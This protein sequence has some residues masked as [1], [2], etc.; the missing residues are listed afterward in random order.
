LYSISSIKKG[1]LGWSKLIPGAG[2]RLCLIPLRFAAQ[3]HA[4][5]R[6]PPPVVVDLLDNLI[7]QAAC[8]VQLV[9]VL[10]EQIVLFFKPLEFP[11]QGMD[12]GNQIT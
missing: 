12:V 4:I 1:R 9:E 2:I 3:A 6:R 10:R 7:A 11:I 8:L 5:E